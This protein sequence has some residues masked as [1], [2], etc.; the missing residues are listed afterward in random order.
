[1]RWQH[2]EF[3]KIVVVMVLRAV[4][5]DGPAGNGVRLWRHGIDA[6]TLDPQTPIGRVAIV[7]ADQH[8]GARLGS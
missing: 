1:M 7:T 4:V 2:Q 8:H 5:A 3:S 6:V